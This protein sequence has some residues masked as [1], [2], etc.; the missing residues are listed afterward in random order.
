MDDVN[1]QQNTLYWLLIR[2]NRNNNDKKNILLLISNDFLVLCLLLILYAHIYT[3]LTLFFSLNFIKVFNVSFFVFELRHTGCRR[4][5][6]PF[7]SSAFNDDLSVASRPISSSL[8][9]P[10]SITLA[11]SLRQDRPSAPPQF[12]KRERGLGGLAKLKE[13]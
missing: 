9:L 4:E 10:C 12:I 1:F 11:I 6:Q 8:W 5:I 13:G 2:W 3:M 7:L